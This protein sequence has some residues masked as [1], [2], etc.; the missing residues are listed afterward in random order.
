M[1]D[2]KQG[3]MSR[4]DCKYFKTYYWWVFH[5]TSHG[6]TKNEKMPDPKQTVI[7]LVEN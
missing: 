6:K 2:P 5:V 1:S 7:L 3:S 4:L